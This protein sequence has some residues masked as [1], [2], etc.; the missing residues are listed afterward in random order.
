MCLDCTA[1]ASRPLSGLVIEHFKLLLVRHAELSGTTITS[2][3]E[4]YNDS[5]MT[6]LVP[7]IHVFFLASAVRRGCPEQARA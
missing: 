3:G 4:V 6:G 1:D 7:A 5:V 2:K